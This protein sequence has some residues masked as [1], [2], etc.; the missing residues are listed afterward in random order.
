MKIAKEVQFCKRKSK[1]LPPIFLE[2][3]LF[4]ASSES[5]ISLEQACVEICKQHGISLSKQSLDERFNKEAVS[6]I[7]LLVTEQIKQQVVASPDIGF[8]DIF[9]QIKLLDSTRFDVP[10][11]FKCLLPGFNGRNTSEAGISIQHEY[12]IKNNRTVHLEIFGAT[13]SDSK[14]AESINKSIEPND[15]IIRD[16]GYYS[17]DNLIDINKND[18]YFISRL[19]TQADVYELNGDGQL[20]KIS[21]EQIHKQMGQLKISQLEKQVYVGKDKKLPV[22]LVIQL[23]PQEIYEKRLSKI[24]KYNKANG[25]QTKDETKERVRFNLFITNVKPEK[26]TLEHVCLLYKIRWQ[27][28]LIF[29]SWKSTFNLD[30]LHKMKYYRYMSLIY[31]KLLLILLNHEIIVN[32]KA[33]LYI[34]T[35]KALSMAKCFKTLAKYSEWIRAIIKNVNRTTKIIEKIEVILSERHWQERR[36]KRTGLLEIIDQFCCMTTDYVIF[37]NKTGS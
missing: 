34:K 16:L 13:K 21:F 7:K 10:D 17:R 30:N 15:L 32:I 24:S 23:M 36:K 1:L 22:R 33:K 28:E 14:Y 18:A 8:L 37:E 6:F 9:N 35:N 20:I 5:N 19:N 27:I 25:H 12:D 29:K 11:Q 4:S 26:I 2:M 3:L 31:S